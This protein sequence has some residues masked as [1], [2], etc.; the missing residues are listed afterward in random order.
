MLILNKSDTNSFWYHSVI[1]IVQIGK[2]KERERER[3]R[4]RE[5]KKGGRKGGREED[6]IT[7]VILG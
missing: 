6:Q 1:R 7:E 3:G 4:K 2:S 5:R